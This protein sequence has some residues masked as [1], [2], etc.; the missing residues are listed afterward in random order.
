MKE[1][2]KCRLCEH[3][4]IANEPSTGDLADHIESHQLRGCVQRIYTTS[5]DFADHLSLKH[6]MKGV[7]HSDM[8]PWGRLQFLEVINGQGLI[9][10]TQL[11]TGGDCCRGVEA[12]YTFAFVPL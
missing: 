2:T 4:D 8:A 11:Q 9:R 1:S 5:K 10:T 12:G 3:L 7:T 6:R